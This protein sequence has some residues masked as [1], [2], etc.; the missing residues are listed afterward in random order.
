MKIG[1]LTFHASHNYGSMLQAYA[2]LHVIMGMG[3]DCKIINL[4][5]DVQKS[6]IQPEIRWSHPRT[7]LSHIIKHPLRTLTLSRKYSRFERFLCENLCCSHELHTH[8]EVGE[9]IRQSGIEAVVVGSDQI[10]NPACWDFDWSYLLDFDF[11][12]RRIAYA[13]SMGHTPEMIAQSKQKRMATCWNRFD[14]LSTREQRGSAFVTSLTGKPCAT[15]LD[16]T[17]LLA[18]NDY[19]RL[20]LSSSLPSEYIFYYT[21]RE[22]PGTFL[23]AQELARQTGLKILV[24]QDSSEYTGTNVIRINDCGPREFINIIHGASYCIGN[25]FHLLAFSLI[26]HR[27]FIMLSYQKDSRMLNILE[28]LGLQDRLVNTDAELSVMNKIDYKKI[29]RKM[30]EMRKSSLKYLANAL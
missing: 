19:N 21:P 30:T 25:S 24:T 18:A 22:E 17:L 10:W 13:P 6:L 3:H 8:A 15:V 14:A 9:Y 2:L 4:R 7:T 12:I 16:P 26:F 20:S 23:K 1:I 11:S 28:P 29:D 5:T 27:E